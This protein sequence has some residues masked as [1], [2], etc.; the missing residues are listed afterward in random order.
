MLENVELE[1]TKSTWLLCEGREKGGGGGKRLVGLFRHWAASSGAPATKD[2]LSR[3][4]RGM[5]TYLL[6][7]YS[8]DNTSI[9]GAYS[10]LQLVDLT[11]VNTKEEM[12]P[13]RSNKFKT[14]RVR[15][16]SSHRILKCYL[17]LIFL[18]FAN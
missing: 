11:K 9:D 17:L 16:A 12:P 18:F 14:S 1:K 6:H 2:R 13:A 15:P 7:V 3:A 4:R 10:A 8:F 5:I